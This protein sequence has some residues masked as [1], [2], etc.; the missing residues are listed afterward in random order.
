MVKQEPSLFQIGNVLVASDIFTE[1][2]CCDLEQCKGACCVEGSSG[3][4]VELDEIGGIED[5]LDTI[6]ND[7][8][9]S[10]QAVIDKQGVAYS[11]ND[12]DLVTSIVNGKDCVFTCYE[13]GICFCA[14]ERAFRAG[15]TRFMKPIS[16]SLYPLREKAFSDGTVGLRV[17]H[18]DIC[19]GAK[20]KGEQLDLPLYKFLQVPLT[21]RF[22]KEWYQQ[23][24]GVAE[25][26]T[27]QHLI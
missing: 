14:L 16:C 25:Q 20:E 15:K 17:H 2:F 12:G 19:K 13:N 23:L 22:G 26:L 6:W 1:K 18:W 11:D 27:A 8:S 4:P 9:A 5:S 21:M 24:C 10:A 3:A 7:L